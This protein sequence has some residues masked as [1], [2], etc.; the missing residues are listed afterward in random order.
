MAIRPEQWS[1]EEDH[2]VINFLHARHVSA[3]QI[4]CQLVEV[5][6][7]EVMSHQSVAKWCSDFKSGRVGITDNERSSR[8][9]AA[10][11][12]ENKANVEAAILGNRRV[13]LS[14]LEHDL[15][16]LHGTI[17]RIVQELGFRKVCARWVLR[18]LSED[19]KAQRMVRALSFLQQCC[20]HL[21]AACN[22]SRVAQYDA[23]LI[24]VPVSMKSTNST[25][26]RS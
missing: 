16:L 1:K 19:H 2:A 8:P 14:E 13:T 6:E 12:P 21:V 11:T 5:Y 22:H 26:L 20:C 4:N 15:G 17:V 24:V 18:A 10:S 25:P 23:A 9:T 3:A 7:E